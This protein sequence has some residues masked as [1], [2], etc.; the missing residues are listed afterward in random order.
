MKYIILAKINIKPWYIRLVCQNTLDICCDL[1]VYS[2]TEA[3]KGIKKRELINQIKRP[4]SRTLERIKYTDRLI[5]E[6]FLPILDLFSTGINIIALICGL[7]ITAGLYGL[8]VIVLIGMIYLILGIFYKSFTKKLSKNR[9]TVLTEITKL[10]SNY[11]SSLIETRMNNK[12]ELINERYKSLEGK[13]ASLSFKLGMAIYSPKILIETLVMVL[14]FLLVFVSLKSTNQVITLEQIGIIITCL[15]RLLPLVNKFFSSIT[16]SKSNSFL[17]KKINEEAYKDVEKD[18]NQN[19][20]NKNKDTNLFEKNNANIP[21]IEIKDCSISYGKNGNI[22]KDFSLKVFESDFISLKGKSGSGKSTI[23]NLISGLIFPN[24]GNIYINGKKTNFK[25]QNELINLRAKIAYV[26]QQVHIIDSSIEE[27]IAWEFYKDK[28]NLNKERIKLLRYICCIEDKN[29]LGK[30]KNSTL[31]EGG[32]SISGG[33]RQRIGIAR[34]LYKGG[35]NLLILD[36][37]LSGVE[38][39]CQQEIIKRLRTNFPKLAIILVTHNEE[40]S[41]LA[42]RSVL[43][44]E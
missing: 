30:S 19:N 23:L 21:I 31:S 25:N 37:S 33:Q 34:S 41:N 8:M 44:G 28:I 36:E 6:L 11:L 17:L 3:L 22:I 18:N 24:K 35:K 40:I 38:E 29:L 2:G 9:D 5:G 43:I 15:Q 27:N 4:N 14:L 7:I 10:I 1:S 39:S 20:K 16:V 26:P 42:K 13:S 12:E 32:N